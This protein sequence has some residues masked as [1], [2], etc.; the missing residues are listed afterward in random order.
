MPR[1]SLG[2]SSVASLPDE[3]QAPSR[4]SHETPSPCGTRFHS[5]LFRDPSD[6]GQDG[7]YL[8]LGHHGAD[9]QA[10]AEADVRDLCAFFIDPQYAPLFDRLHPR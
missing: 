1:D 3:S 10:E 9:P 5:V 6:P 2:P 4:E 8:R 7:Y